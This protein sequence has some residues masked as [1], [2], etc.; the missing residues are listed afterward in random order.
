MINGASVRRMYQEKGPRQFVHEFYQN[1]G[2]ED[3]QT[4]RRYFDPLR[5]R[6]VIENQ[7]WRPENISL[8]DL[9]QSILAA[10]SDFE[11]QELLKTPAYKQVDVLESGTDIVPSAFANVSAFNSAVAGLLEAKFLESYNRPTF[12]ADQLCQTIPSHKR[13]EKFIGISLPG[14]TAEERK[15]GNRH[16]RLQ[17][18]ERYV[19]TPDTVNRANA[20]DVTREAVMFDNTRQLLEQCEKAAETLAL[21]KEY[22]VIDTFLGVNNTYTY[23]GTN[24]NT[25]LTSGNWVNKITSNALVDWTQIDA[26]NQL[27][28]GMTDQET[29]QPVEVVPRDLFVM[30]AKFWTARGIL[31]YTVSTRF[32]NSGAERGDGPNILG[33]NLALNLVGTATYPYALKRATASDGLNVSSSTAKNYWWIGDFRKAFGYVQNLPPTINRANPNDYEMAD[34]GLVF[35]LFADEMGVPCV[36]EPRQ[37]VFC[38]G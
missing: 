21:R 35:S 13:S 30:P 37:V 9:A 5:D 33:E 10:A 16:P 6:N 4:G 2:L 1:L 19:T 31:R 17:L 25:Y 23:N 34:R 32:T 18:S 8:R 36:L 29:G 14:D 28:T 3:P 26:A 11:L 27:F 12:I 22:V 38:T 7:A 24:Y 20:V 15:P